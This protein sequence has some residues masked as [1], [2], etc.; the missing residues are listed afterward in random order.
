MKHTGC[1]LSRELLLAPSGSVKVL[2][3]DYFS[4]AV[5]DFQKTI[6]L[7]L[8]NDSNFRSCS[9]TIYMESQTKI[10]ACLC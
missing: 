1:K 5:F 4:G 10:L 2:H 3:S 9:V 7:S 8:L 6:K